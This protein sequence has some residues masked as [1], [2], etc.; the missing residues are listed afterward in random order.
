MAACVC[1]TNCRAALL[2]HLSNA[3][4]QHDEARH[5]MACR[6]EA[7]HSTAQHSTA[8]HSTAQHSTAQHSTAQHST[9]QHDTAQR[10]AATATNL[11]EAL[12][13]CIDLLLWDANGAIKVAAGPN[14]AILCFVVNCAD[15]GPLQPAQSRL[16]QQLLCHLHE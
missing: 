9:A 3:L 16:V 1:A 15:G 8:Q 6:S 14:G 5:N 11:S 12:D 7:R 2:H 4:A 10:S 13:S